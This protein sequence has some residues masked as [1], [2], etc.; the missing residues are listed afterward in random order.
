MSSLPTRLD[1]CPLVDALI[2]IRFESSIVGSAIFGIIYNHISDD[3]KGNVTNL[4]I[5][6]IPE[7]IRKADP[8]LCFKPLYRIDSDE[9]ILQIGDDVLCISSKIPYVGW[10]NFS[11]R[12]IELIKKI[13]EAKIINK[14][15]RIGHRYVNFFED[16]IMDKLTISKPD[17]K[18]YDTNSI[19][20]RID[21]KDKDNFI[22]T[23]QITN[24]ATYKEPQGG[25]I[26][27]GSLIDIDSF[28]V[29]EDNYFLE[30]I[31]NEIESVHKCE[32]TMFFSLLKEEFLESLKP[33]YE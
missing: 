30:N 24:S 14:V 7:Q 27:S 28:K 13:V 26:L 22:D 17:I 4:P 33:S 29:Y 3:F 32:K 25:E 31:K 12:A 11:S 16:D 1:K 19:L 15:I 2:E 6:Q 8:N 9:Y 21:S 10:K 20:I 18:N 5:L 23:V